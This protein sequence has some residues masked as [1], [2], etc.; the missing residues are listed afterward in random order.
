LIIKAENDQIFLLKDRLYLERAQVY[1]KLGAHDLAKTD[2]ENAG[3]QNN[4]FNNPIPKP[5]L[6]LDEETFYAY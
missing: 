4:T 6:M 2:L 1:K 5:M 3:V